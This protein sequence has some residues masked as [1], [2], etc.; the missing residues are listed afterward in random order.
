LELQIHE[1]ADEQGDG[2][3]YEVSGK[4]VAS[5]EKMFFTVERGN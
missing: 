2:R 5:L 1:A 3:H 4:W